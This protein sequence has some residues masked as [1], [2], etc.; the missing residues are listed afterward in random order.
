M[1]KTIR[2]K[3]PNEM[4]NNIY[5]HGYLFKIYTTVAN[6]VAENLR[7]NSDKRI[8]KTKKAKLT[9]T[10]EKTKIQSI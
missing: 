5:S 2:K 4:T 7:C 10:K 9:R 6:I 8:D 3:R 1:K